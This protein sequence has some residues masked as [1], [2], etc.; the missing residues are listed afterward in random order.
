MQ[1]TGGSLEIGVTQQK[2][3]DAQVGAGIQQV[4]CE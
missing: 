1:V 3:N 4:S 2:L